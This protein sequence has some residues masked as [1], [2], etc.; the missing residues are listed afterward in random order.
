MGGA[1]R[2]AGHLALTDLHGVWHEPLWVRERVAHALVFLWTDCPIANA[3][4]PEIQAIRRDYET[5]G[6]R[7]YL[8]HLQVDLTVAAARKHADEYGRAGPILIDREH[9]LA[10]ALEVSVV[11]QIAEVG[12]DGALLYRG[13][14][15]NLFGDLG[16]KRPAATR[17]EL[18]DALAAV[19]AARRVEVPRTAAVG[20]SVGG[21]TLEPTVR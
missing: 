10:R 15:D 7:F 12:R 4:A 13:R 19:V 16:K 17:H 8:V 9:V 1:D 18:R 3:Y 20:C 21:V 2:S 11:P 6:V 14:I 5:R